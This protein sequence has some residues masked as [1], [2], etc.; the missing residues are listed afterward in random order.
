VGAVA[1]S[2]IE[3]TATIESADR[4]GALIDVPPHVVEQLGGGGRIKVRAQFDGIGYQ[5]SIV[6]YSGR[7]VL[8]VLKSIREKLG[9]GPGDDLVV[10][11]EVDTT[12]RRVEIPVELEQ[13]FV[14]APE[15]RAAFEGLSYSH[16][17]EH[18]SHI[19][20]AKKPETRQRRAMRT[21]ERLTAQT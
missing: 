20:E 4:G 11:L 6:T 10:R 5:G 12:Q 14:S 7:R 9:K 2:V 16:Q 13:A 3:F 21:V 1:E 15:A 18:V 8:G 17:R 19:V